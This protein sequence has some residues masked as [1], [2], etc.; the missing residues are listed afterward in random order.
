[1]L[2]TIVFQNL[3]IPQITRCYRLREFSELHMLCE[4]NVQ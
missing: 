1:M 3:K 4:M 2:L